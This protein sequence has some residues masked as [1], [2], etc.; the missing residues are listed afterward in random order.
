MWPFSAFG[1]RRVTKLLQSYAANGK[2]DVAKEIDPLRQLQN[3]LDVVSESELVELPVFQDEAT[4]GKAVAEYL[5]Q[6]GRLQQ[7]LNEVRRYAADVDHFSATLEALLQKQQG[8]PEA[9]L[10][11]EEFQSAL[12][13]FKDA[14][15]AYLAHAG[16]KLH[17]T[18]TE[19][20]AKDLRHIIDNKTQLVNWVPWV[21]IREQAQALG[22]SPFL[23]A[24]KSGEINNTNVDFLVAYFNWWLPLALD[25]SSELRGFRHWSHE[26][27]IT[28]FRKRDKRV[29]ELASD[30]ILRKA[31]HGLPNKDAVPRRSELGTLRHQLGLQR[32][33]L[34]IR[35]LIEGMPTTFT[36]LAPCMLMSPLSVAQYLPADQTQFDVVIFDE[37]SQITT[38]DA[39][40]SIARA[41]QSIIVGDPKQL[42]PTNFFGRTDDE[43]QDD[44]AEYE[45]DLPS[46]LE[47]AEAAGLPP[48]QLNWHY[49]SRD[50][51]LISFSNHHYY[52][53]RLITFPSPKTESDALVFHKNNGIYARGTGRTNI[54]EARKIVQFAKSRLED[55]FE[56]PEENRPTLGVITFNIQQQELILNLFDEARADNPN[57]EW[58]FSDDRE[59]PLI[60]KNLENIQGD[61]RDVMCF[62]I[63]FGKDNAGKMSMSFGAL[64]LDGGE[65]RLNVAVTRARSEMHVFSSIEGDDIDTSR[66]KSLGV[67]HLK[68]FLDYAKKG[69]IALPAMNSDSV[70]DTESPFEEAVMA[71]LRNKGWEVR[72]QIG[73]S[74]YRIDLGV[75][76]P[77]HAGAYLAGIECDGASYHSSASARDRDKIREG[78]LR[79]LGWSIIRIWSTD[80]FMNP[81]DALKRVHDELEELLNTS[82]IREKE[83]AAKAQNRPEKQ[84]EWREAPEALVAEIAGQEDS[85]AAPQ[86]HLPLKINPA[87]S[88]PLNPVTQDSSS[89]YAKD[90][91]IPAEDTT[92]EGANIDWPV[93]PN[94]D[95]FFDPEYRPVLAKMI[96]YLVEKEGPIE[97]N[98]LARAICKAHGW[99]RTG[100]KIRQ[101]IDDCMGDNESHQEGETTFV[102]APATYLEEVPYRA[103][104]GRSTM[105]ISRHELFGL[106]AAHP[107][108]VMSEDQ[109]RDL[110]VMLEIKR[111]SATVKSHLENCL[112]MYFMHDN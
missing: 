57:L 102:W 29:Q 7:A 77:D 84:D 25:A 28:E 65:K 75:I 58:Y 38:W 110:A 105:E 54:V 112:S 23:D 9:A 41:K 94:A 24:L 68:N 70:G 62:S 20:L 89:R 74:G 90:A 88:L 96:D 4:D 6:A 48:I 36:K 8:K 34:S 86:L 91:Q 45:K 17:F 42:P 31:T 12:K 15:D 21:A 49:R 44:L 16:G 107:E 82:R 18:S 52:G 30:Q 73:V 47:E 61:E 60:V 3:N 50:E 19:S 11:A 100:A 2:V 35:K 78:V 32:P 83:E 69:S 106:I 67:A 99:Q 43:D 46:I 39:V 72:P 55:W 93:Q 63:T 109:V 101:Q 80:W 108:L 85:V 40:G 26:D 59:E 27:L 53:G 56:Y 51:S 5:E 37:A 92:G 76:H 22:L 33:S 95:R 1:R 66:T 71:A 13:K 79:N 81:T 103:I 14:C 87:T 104:E 97:A 64:N 10:L 111:L 98:R